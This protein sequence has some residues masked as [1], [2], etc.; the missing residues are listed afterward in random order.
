VAN[1]DSLIAVD[2]LA[3]RID[4]NDIRIL[5]CRFDLFAPDAGRTAYLSG[6]IPWAVYADLDRDL[7]APVDP[8]SG[9]HPL[10]SV[11]SSAST[12]S[13]MGI[14]KDTFVVV[15]DERGGAVAA[16]AWWM[17]RWLGHNKV[18]VLDG[19]LV[20]WRAG[21]LPLVAGE[22]AVAT[23]DFVPRPQAD[24]TTST[25]QI[26][27]SM[28]DGQLLVDARA[29]SRFAGLHEPI[30]SVAGHIPGAVNLPYERCLGA[31]GRFRPRNELRQLFAETLGT[32]SESP[33][34]AMCG[35]GVT[36][37][38]LILAAA[39]AGL[40]QPKLY[41]GSWSEWIRDSRRPVSVGPD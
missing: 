22:E 41:V 23:T 39:V 25:D 2:E 8:A 5:D 21:A 28:D 10:P 31:D 19:G 40:P 15:Y 17:L 7:A 29:E 34:T 32:G 38:H 9:R 3:R 27:S 16:R 6:H 24:W 13:R 12:F 1:Q 4:D 35:S 37:C 26:L 11:T 20:A 14:G 18:A 33:W 30:D 36:A